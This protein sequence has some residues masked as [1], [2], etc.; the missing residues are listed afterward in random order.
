[1]TRNHW[2]DLTPSML[3]AV[4]MVVATLISARAAEHRWLVLAGPLFLALA[5]V[6]A[7]MLASRLGG[8]SSSPSWAALLMG[9]SC[10]LASL[11][12]TLRDPILV[13]T[14]IPVI[15]IASWVSL[16]FALRPPASCWPWPQTRRR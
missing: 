12:V 5:I 2:L 3:V 6:S 8:K 10:L 11:I 7:D 4:G 1:M 13:K 9:S 15:G 14:F 16:P